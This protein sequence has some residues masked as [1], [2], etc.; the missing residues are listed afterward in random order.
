MSRSTDT[1]RIV[2][3]GLITHCTTVIRGHQDAD[4]TCHHARTSYA[5]INLVWGGVMITLYSCAAVHGILE[6]FV[7]ARSAA[8]QLP[9]QIPPPPRRYES[10]FARPMV[11]M[12]FTGRPT[13]AAVQQSGPARAGYRVIH[14]VDLHMGPITWQ[15]RDQAGLRSAIDLLHRGY[16]FAVG[17]PRRVVLGSAQGLPASASRVLLGGLCSTPRRHS[18]TPRSM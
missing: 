15:I 7:T 16:K 18:C 1:T 11:A 12:E 4:V 8:A 10:V 3:T 13:Y 2:P 17:R 5:R 14:W 6:A 9:R